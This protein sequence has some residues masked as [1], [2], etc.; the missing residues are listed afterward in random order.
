VGHISNMTSSLW[1]FI[2]SI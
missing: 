1:G 2:E